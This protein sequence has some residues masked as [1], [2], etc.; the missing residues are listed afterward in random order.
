MVDQSADCPEAAKPATVRLVDVVVVTCLLIVLKLQSP[1]RSDWLINQSAD[2]PE[3]DAR[4]GQTGRYGCSKWGG[5]RSG[6]SI[7]VVV[8]SLPIVLKPEPAT[9]RLEVDDL[10]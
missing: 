3:A 8:T 9:A 5:V 10:N 1:P 4:H 6:W 2:C 7:E